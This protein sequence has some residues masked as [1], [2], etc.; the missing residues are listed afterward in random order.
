MAL[1][2][3][4]S[5]LLEATLARIRAGTTIFPPSTT[6]WTVSRSI[7]VNTTNFNVGRP[8]KTL[9]RLNLGILYLE[10]RVPVM[11]QRPLRQPPHGA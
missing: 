11:N 2:A 10:V 3:L 6:Q 1:N 5:Q 9:F 8:T 4:A 7:D